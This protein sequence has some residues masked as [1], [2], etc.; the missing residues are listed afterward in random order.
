MLRM[1][2]YNR[3]RNR[4]KLFIRVGRVGDVLPYNSRVLNADFTHTHIFT[5]KIRTESIS[6]SVY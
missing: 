6:I 4:I 1:K 3:L 5:N 2:I